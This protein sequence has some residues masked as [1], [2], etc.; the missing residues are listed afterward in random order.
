[1][2]DW[3]PA[4]ARDFLDHATAG[5]DPCIIV[6]PADDRGVVRVMFKSAE[7][8]HVYILELKGDDVW[9]DALCDGARTTHKTSNLGQF[10]DLA[11]ERWPY[12]QSMQRMRAL[13]AFHADLK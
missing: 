3:T 11:L 7:E 2:L 5:G 8:K 9:I 6:S 1:M 12:D 10:I 13:I 4:A